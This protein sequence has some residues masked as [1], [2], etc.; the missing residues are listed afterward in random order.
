M[1]TFSA[2]RRGYHGSAGA[3]CVGS[4]LSFNLE[5][6]VRSIHGPANLLLPDD[7][8]TAVDM[9]FGIKLRL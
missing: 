6:T 9:R 8:L 5:L 7:K 2:T 3:E 4:R 1:R